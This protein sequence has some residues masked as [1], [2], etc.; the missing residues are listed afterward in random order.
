MQMINGKHNKNLSYR[1]EDYRNS[2]WN[3][4]KY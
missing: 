1:N 3:K 4:Q 2:K